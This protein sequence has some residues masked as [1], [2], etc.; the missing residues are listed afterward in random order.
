[1]V[2]C[3][4]VECCVKVCVK[5]CVPVD[6]IEADFVDVCE[7]E[8]VYT[9]DGVAVLV[10]VEDLVIVELAVADCV[11]DCVC[12]MDDVSACVTVGLPVGLGV[13]DK[14]ADWL[15]VLETELDTT[16]TYAT[17]VD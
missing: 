17:P 13:R 16:N 2:L 1:M 15:E 9:C 4:G 11:K 10:P 5:L 6:V 3:E 7:K 8:G 14:L 12:V